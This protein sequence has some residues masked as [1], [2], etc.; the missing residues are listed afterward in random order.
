[1]ARVHKRVLYRTIAQDPLPTMTMGQATSGFQ[2]GR[3]FFSTN[4]TAPTTPT[5]EIETAMASEL[6]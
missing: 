4:A 1:M 3:K 2:P 6:E 5:T